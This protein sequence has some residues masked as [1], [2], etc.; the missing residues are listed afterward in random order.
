MYTDFLLSANTRP[1]TDEDLVEVDD[2]MHAVI[3]LV[4]AWLRKAKEIVKTAGPDF[5]RDPDIF[6][7]DEDVAILAA[8]PELMGLLDRMFC[9]CHRCLRYYLYYDKNVIKKPNMV[10][11]PQHNDVDF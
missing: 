11:D 5:R 7:V 6:L 2:Y 1:Y 3:R 10:S 9:G 4:V 8:C